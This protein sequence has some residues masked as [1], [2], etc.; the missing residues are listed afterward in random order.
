MSSLY[1]SM[2]LLRWFGDRPISETSWSR[3]IVRDRPRHAIPDGAVYDAVDFLFDKPGLAYKRGG[4]AFQSSALTGAIIIA[5][6]APEYTADSRVLA[7]VSDGAS[8]RTLYDCTTSTAS[9]IG[10]VNGAQPIENP[11][12]FEQK[13]ILC[14]GIGVSGT[15]HA[16]Q[17]IYLVTGTV[18]VAD[19]GGSPPNARYSCVHLDRLIL[20]NTTANPN[21]LYF[22]A[23]SDP[24]TWDTT[25]AWIDVGEPITGLASVQGV[26][27]IFSRGATWRVLGSLPPGSVDSNGAQIDDMELQPVSGA[28]GCM[29]ARSIV[30]MSG[31]VYWA[32]ES[33]IHFSNGGAPTS[34]T[35]RTDGTGIGTLWASAVSGWSPELAS[36]V[37]SGVWLNKWLFITVRHAA[38]DAQSGA[39]YQFLWYQPTDTWTRLAD[40][41]TA[42]MY[43]TRFAPTQEIYA[44]CGD[45]GDPVRLL[46]LSGLFSPSS[47]N[48]ADANAENVLPTLT[49]RP[50]GLELGIGEKHFTTGHVTY[51]LGESA[52]LTVQ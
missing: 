42:D 31:L 13:V 46:K 21:R 15:Y 36:V 9:S 8:T 32:H 50:L 4:S 11:S 47:S 17:K 51:R 25:N 1:P 7:I 10:S 29:D 24:E 43:A 35:D 28:V 44:A 26:L 52:T 48:E 23:V 33:G 18:T 5:V 38:T 16:P 34:I 19:L 14:D 2:R 12:F 20:A 30:Y 27:L 22:S 6:M 37:C 49:M 3:G 45:T 39:R 40:G 41:V